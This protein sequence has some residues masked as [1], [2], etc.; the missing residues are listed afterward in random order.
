MFSKIIINNL[1]KTE[2]LFKLENSLK[3]RR[4][5]SRHNMSKCTTGE[6]VALKLTVLGHFVIASDEKDFKQR[7][8]RFRSCLKIY[9][10]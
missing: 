2:I 10:S 5:N 3:Q 6:V 8:R 9:K 4:C 7:L 1:R